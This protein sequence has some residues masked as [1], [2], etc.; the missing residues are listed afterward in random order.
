MIGISYGEIRKLLY[1]MK[2]LN[3][4]QQ[5]VSDFSHVH[6]GQEW[7]NCE[8]MKAAAAAWQ[9]EKARRRKTG[10]QHGGDDRES[11]YNKELST[12]SDL[13]LKEQIKSTE[14]SENLEQL[15][16]IY[17]S[18]SN[19]PECN[20]AFTT[21]KPLIQARN[22]LNTELESARLNETALKNAEEALK[23]AKKRKISDFLLNETVRTK[24]IDLATNT[25]E[26]D[27]KNLYANLIHISAYKDE[28]SKA[29]AAHKIA[30]DSCIYNTANNAADRYKIADDNYH[31]E[32]D[33]AKSLYEEQE[34][35]KGR[36]QAMERGKV[37]RQR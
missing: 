7:G 26:R 4:Y 25:R 11:V 22:K 36:K 12:M 23:T 6:S 34:I 32:L 8:F 10:Q 9:L 19:I 13:V 17:H 5:F 35:R 1:S 2:K 21:E 14:D 31:Q 16:K 29:K 28:L 24:R 15:N 18:M 20:D 27:K 37:R 3:E 30:K 33:Y